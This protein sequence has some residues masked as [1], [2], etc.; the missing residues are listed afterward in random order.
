MASLRIECMQMC[1]N[2][3]T[4][5]SLEALRAVGQLLGALALITVEYRLPSWGHKAT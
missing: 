1:G 5:S 2:H 4:A 3:R